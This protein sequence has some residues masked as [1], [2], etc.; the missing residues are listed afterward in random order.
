[1]RWETFLA[2]KHTL[3]T[4]QRRSEQRRLSS[5]RG[6]GPADGLHASAINNKVN[7][8]SAPVDRANAG[9]AHQIRL[10][11]TTASVEDASLP[12]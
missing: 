4:C 6:V 11:S 8:N 12:G 5:A 9:I 1:M 2:M 3:G 7:R 10:R